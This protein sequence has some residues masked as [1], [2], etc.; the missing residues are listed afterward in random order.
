MLSH[1]SVVSRNNAG[2]WMYQSRLRDK[3]AQSLPRLNFWRWKEFTRLIFLRMG[4]RFSRFLPLHP[5]KRLCNVIRKLIVRRRLGKN[6]KRK[7]YTMRKADQNWCVAIMTSNKYRLRFVSSP[8]LSHFRPLF[9]AFFWQAAPAIAEKR[10]KRK[11]HINK[12][13]LRKNLRDEVGTSATIEREMKR[14]KSRSC[15]TRMLSQCFAFSSVSVPISSTTWSEY[16][17]LLK[18]VILDF[19]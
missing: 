10:W 14:R 18:S 11:K 9:P 19:F 1:R 15:R 6:G 3:V 12:E 2:E 16:K 8:S 13:E 17:L 4:I 7:A 5:L